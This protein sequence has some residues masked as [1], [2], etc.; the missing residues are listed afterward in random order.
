MEAR[1][2]SRLPKHW[3]M[4]AAS[5]VVVEDA[6]LL[7]VR[8]LQG[9]WAG[10]GGWLEPGETPEQA[11]LR[12]LREE[13][14]A[15]GE[16]MRVFRPFIAWNVREQDPPVS[17]LLFP[18]GVALMS[19]DLTPDPREVTGVAWVPQAELAGYEMLPQIR[20]LYDQRLDEWMG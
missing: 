17:F 9:F 1:H 14:G 12:E 3:M 5:A 4:M 8:D 18:F 7:L 2:P 15:V 19:R 13:L 10:V 6:K 16:V 11:V 20:A